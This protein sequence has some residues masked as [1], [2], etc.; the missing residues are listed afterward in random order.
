MT[1]YRVLFTV[2]AVADFDHIA[3]FIAE[4]SPEKA[5]S[6]VTELQKRAA[7]LL[8]FNPKAG[9]SIGDHRLAV[10]GRYVVIY[11]IDD[12]E[13]SVTVVIV[14]EGHRDWQRLLETRS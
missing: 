14:T 4:D 10:F 1:R 8:S 11:R 9:R 12:E 3:D 5:L 6:F 2:H 7:A 13:R